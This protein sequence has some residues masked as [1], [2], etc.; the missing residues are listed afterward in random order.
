MNGQQIIKPQKLTTSDLKFNV[1]S[2]HL[3]NNF[4]DLSPNHQKFGKI[5][6]YWF[7]NIIKSD[8][9]DGDLEII[10]KKIDINETKNQDYFKFSISLEMELI[11]KTQDLKRNKTYKV[12][13]SEYGEISG[14]FSIKDQE[15]LSLNIMH[16]SID[17]VSKKLLELI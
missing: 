1:V 4:L 6:D 17:S 12:N 3:S 16:Q 8:G 14:S 5:V 9:F 15:N 10:L 2:K 13:S 7:S 11:E